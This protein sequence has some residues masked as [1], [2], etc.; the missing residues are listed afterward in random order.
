M[1]SVAD[2]LL[3]AANSLTEQ[4]QAR[5]SAEDLVVAAWRSYPDSFG[6][7]GHLDDNGTPAYPDS[8][9]VFAEIMGSKPL[10]KRGYLR[11]VG[12]K[13]YSLTESGRA[14]A[15]RI[16]SLSHEGIRKASLSRGVESELLRLLQSRA[17]EKEMAGR[18]SEITFFDAC[19]FW[20]I[21]P[22]SSAVELEGRIADFKGI[23]FAAME[24]AG[25]KEFVLVH[26][27][28]PISPEDLRLLEEVH[29]LLLDKFIQELEII[30]GRTD[31]RA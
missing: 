7:S 17:V 18:E 25:E 16:S 19:A 12:T 21:S 11:K 27:G 5:F 4:G 24:M 15:R 26:G 1:L 28:R 8:N 10:R 29:E 31:E 23:L 13:L 30:R 9:R 14:E 3:L 22:R 20:N 6:L 2:K